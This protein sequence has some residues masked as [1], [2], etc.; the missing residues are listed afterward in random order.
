MRGMELPWWDILEG[1]ALF[2]E[3]ISWPHRC[4]FDAHW[5]WVFG[6]FSVDFE[7]PKVWYHVQLLVTRAWACFVVGGQCQSGVVICDWVLALSSFSLAGSGCVFASLCVSVELLMYSYDKYI[8][9]SPTLHFKQSWV[10]V[11][12]PS[13]IC[14]MCQKKFTH[15]HYILKAL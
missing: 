4:Y 3:N 13:R 5:D 14:T 11:V 7:G 9:L 12:F 6:M 2:W 10:H 8:R 1:Y 15:S